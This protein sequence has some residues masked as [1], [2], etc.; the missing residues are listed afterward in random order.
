MQYTNLYCIG[1]DFS[2]IM[3]QASVTKSQYRTP[4]VNIIAGFKLL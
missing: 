1:N 3:K 2:T 4:K